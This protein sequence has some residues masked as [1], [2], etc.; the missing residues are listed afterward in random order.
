MKRV[1]FTEEEDNFLL[2]NIHKCRTLYDLADLFNGKFERHQTNALNITKHL[3]KLGV[4]KGTH[5]IRKEKI[6]S[7]NKIGTVITNKDGKKA[8]VQTENGYVHANTY[9]KEKY[10]PESRKDEMLIHL[11][12][13]YSDF[14]LENIALVS[15]SIYSSLMWRKW[16]FENPELTKTAI[17]TAQLLEFFPDLRH[18]E[19]QYYKCNKEAIWYEKS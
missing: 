18:N 14:S 15:K 3:S 11:N 12:G 10:F 1:N 6:K 17:L 8:R 19:N 7:K 5:N 16:I 13:D 4:K 9:F 2:D